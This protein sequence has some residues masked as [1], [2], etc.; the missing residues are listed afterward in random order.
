MKKRIALPLKENFKEYDTRLKKVLSDMRR[1]LATGHIPG[2]KKDQ[3]CTG[4]SMKDLCMPST[5]PI[6][7]LR[8][9]IEKIGKAE[10]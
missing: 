9:E 3:K 10:L 4:C 7:N 8:A 2:I 1:N 5:K 6:K